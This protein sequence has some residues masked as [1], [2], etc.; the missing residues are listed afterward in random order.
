MVPAIRRP[1]I[2]RN[3]GRPELF[4]PT[5]CISEP[6]C[7]TPIFRVTGFRSYSRR[8]HITEAEIYPL[9]L[10]NLPKYFGPAI[11]S[12][13]GR[14]TTEQPGSTACISNATA[15]FSPPEAGGKS[16]MNPFRAARQSRREGASPARQFFQRP[17]RKKAGGSHGPPPGQAN[18][19]RAVS[20]LPGM[21]HFLVASA[22]SSWDILAKASTALNSSPSPLATLRPYSG[23]ALKNNAV[24]RN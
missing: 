23:S 10:Q 17:G 18:L 16:G 4:L 22:R 6:L 13:K 15:S 3:G 1:P 24:W 9:Q 21:D 19:R 7:R 20:T 5:E 8:K 12:Y 2:F 11:E 14:S